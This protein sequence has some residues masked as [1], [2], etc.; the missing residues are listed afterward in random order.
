MSKVESYLELVDHVQNGTKVKVEPQAYSVPSPRTRLCTLEDGKITSI[1]LS[2]SFLKS[3]W[4]TGPPTEWIGSWD[5]LPHACAYQTFMIH[6]AMKYKFPRSLSMVMGEYFESLAI[7]GGAYGKT[8]SLPRNTRTGE[9]LAHESRILDA[10]QR[11]KKLADVSGI[12]VDT[13]T[14]QIEKSIPILDH[15]FD[16][17]RV[18]V[19]VVAD[20]ISPFHFENLDY[21]LAVV[22]LKLTADRLSDFANPKQPWKNFCWGSPSLMTQ[23]QGLL[24]SSVFGLPFLNIVFDYKAKNP[25]YT[26]VP[27]KTVISHPDDNEAKLRDREM[28]QGIK[29]T[30]ATLYDWND[31]EWPRNPGSHCAKCI[32]ES[33]EAK[34]IINHV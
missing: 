13:G 22:D 9:P 7:G 28:L 27:I 12:I 17:V 4:W 24:Y 16:D 31:N 14:T 32:V 5:F 19:K 8:T 1:V 34:K 2:Q 6:I 29:K 3:I 11:F 25:G 26:I 15:G 30:V 10:V 33:C 23:L 20:I 18:Y 21:D